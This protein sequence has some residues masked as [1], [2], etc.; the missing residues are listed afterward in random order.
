MNTHQKTIAWVYEGSLLKNLSVSYI[1]A[2]SELSKMGWNVIF[3]AS[4]A[5]VLMFDENVNVVLLDRPDIYLLGFMIYHFNVLIQL[6]KLFS[7]LDVVFINPASVILLIPLQI[8]R[9]IKKYHVKFVMDTRDIACDGPAIK[10]L[11]WNIYNWCAFKLA[12]CLADGQTTITNRMVDLIKIPPR[13]LLGIWPSGV[14]IDRYSSVMEQR[15]WSQS[16]EPM[17]V[18]YIG[19]VSYDRN[20][21][22]LCKAVDHLSKNGVNV[23]LKIVGTGPDH[24]DLQH[25][26][27]EMS[28][29]T[30]MQAIPKT[31]VPALLAGFDIGILPFNS[32][33]KSRV[34]SFLK[35]FEY[36]AAGMPIIA[37]R[38]VSHSDVL[39]EDYVVWA[40]DGSQDD[41]EKA[42]KVAYQKRAEFP[43]MGALAKKDVLNWTWNASVKK[44]SQALN[45]IL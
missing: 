12:N 35:M 5:P 23:S 32:T 8:L 20:I 42:I 17:R 14:N 34:S 28:G 4:E 13:Q 33:P 15:K 18:I 24:A 38:I 3:I 10:I 36:M 43:N 44:L 19:S 31:D 27:K 25:R 39:K 6:V 9:A 30:V 7:A 2:S 40:G 26:S 11:Y 1:E 21:L 37:T 22:T 45:S 16:L 41:L 29:V